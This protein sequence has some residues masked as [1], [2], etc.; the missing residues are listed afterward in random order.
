MEEGVGYLGF[1]IKYLSLH[2]IKSINGYAEENVFFWVREILTDKVLI[3]GW[4]NR[5]K[6]KKMVIGLKK[7]L[8]KRRRKEVKIIEKR[9]NV[10]KDRDCVGRMKKVLMKI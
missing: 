2:Y 9:A 4:K 8:K 6:E 3:G 5:R 7:N 10:V 1:L